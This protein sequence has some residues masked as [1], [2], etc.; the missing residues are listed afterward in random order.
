MFC[1]SPS[2]GHPL[3][4]SSDPAGRRRRRIRP[5]PARLS[6][7]DT[8]L[9]GSPRGKGRRR[10]CSGHWRNA[11]ASLGIVQRDQFVGSDCGACGR[12]HA[13]RFRFRC[14]CRGGSRECSAAGIEK[15]V[16]SVGPGPPVSDPVAATAAFDP[17]TNSL[18]DIRVRGY[19]GIGKLE[20]EYSRNPARGIP[21]SRENAQRSCN[22]NGI[23]P[24]IDAIAAD[25]SA[26]TCGAWKNR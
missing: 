18:P 26:S 1:L 25:A 14:R 21:Y 22:T 10:E 4:V 2:L 5:G 24:C 11:R 17:G 6:R 12:R 19:S 16:R 8:R 13:R 9:W 7:A 20:P 15:I 23:R 3:A